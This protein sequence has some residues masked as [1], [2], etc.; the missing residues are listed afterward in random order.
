MQ[1]NI[2]FGV[3]RITKSFSTAPTVGQLKSNQDIRAA[4]GYGDN[5]KVVL[6]GVELPDDVTVGNGQE[7]V[8][9]TAANRKAS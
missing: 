5:V 6:N 4:L 8:I 9:E 2:R 3:D 1:V 7:L